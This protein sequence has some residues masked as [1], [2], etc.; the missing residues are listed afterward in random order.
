MTPRLRRPE[1]LDQPGLDPRESDRALSDLA[2][3]NRRLFAFRPVVR[4]LLPRVSRSDR[5][6]RL[7]DL[8]T[9]AGDLGPTLE[10]A[11]AK[12]GLQ[13]E[14]VGVDRNLAHLLFGHRAG[15]RQL[16][17]VAD[18]GALPFADGAVDWSLSTLF[19]HHFDEIQS[20]RVLGEKVRVARSGTL[21]VDLHRSVVASLI[22]RI[23]LPLFG[24]G[25]VACYDGKLSIDQAW[26]LDE[27]ARLAEGFDVI[28]L[29]RRFPFRFSLILRCRGALPC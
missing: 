27:V 11:A 28:E 17:V 16:R 21:V 23:L 6:L 29:R 1:L 10:R 22:V 2:R 25:R 8:G 20:R 9:G 4:A 15:H 13:L 7:L 5:R 24:V 18:A 3:V 12:R 14:I 26:K 19:L